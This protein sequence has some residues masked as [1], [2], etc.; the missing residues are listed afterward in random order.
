MNLHVVYGHDND[1]YAFRERRD[2]V[3]CGA[4]GAL[5][6]KWGDQQTIAVDDPTSI[7]KDISTTYDGVVIVSPRFRKVVEEAGLTGL[8][9]G[10]L[11]GGYAV[12]RATR[13][14]AFDSNGRKT[15]FEN[16]CRECGNYQSVVGATPAFLMPPVEVDPKEFVWTDIEF[17]SGDEKSPLLL[18]GDEAAKVLRKAKLKGL[19]FAEVRSG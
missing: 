4:C 1:R 18:C 7:P 12:L 3:R 14:V 2:V 17:G 9:F 15:R 13:R 6:D 19:D 8:A 10:E 11:G 5:T 16:Q